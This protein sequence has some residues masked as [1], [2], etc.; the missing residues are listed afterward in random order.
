[1]ILV[2]TN[3]WA[4]YFN[5]R[6]TPH[7]ERLDSALATEED[8][9]VIPI[10]ITEVLQGFRSDGGFRRAADVLLA[11]P[12]MAP[13]VA[14]HVSAARLY[15]SLRRK[16]STVRGAVDC[17]IAQFA[18]DIDAMLLSPDSDFRH[19]AENSRLRLWEPT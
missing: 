14:C 13:D 10:I 16:G 12:V 15:R 5:G 8:L 2:D 6:P 11:L 4:D 1:M 9:T 18:I 19:I 3:T 17:V 7:V